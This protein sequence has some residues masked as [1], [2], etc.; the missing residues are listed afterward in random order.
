MPPKPV[1]YISLF[2]K[3]LTKLKPTTLGR[4]DHEY[5]FRGHADSVENILPKIYRKKPVVGKSTVRDKALI[6]NEDKIFKEIIMRA[7][8]E[9]VNEH[10][11]IEKLVKMQHY[12]LSTRL[13][14]VTSNPLVALYFAAQHLTKERE[15]G[16]VVILKIPKNEI[17]FYDSDTVGILANIAKMKSDFSFPEKKSYL[18]HEIRKDVPS[19]SDIIRLADVNSVVPVKVKLNNNRIVRQSGAFLLYG[20]N[21]EKNKPAKINPH[22]IERKI[23]I[24]QKDKAGLLKSLDL[25]GIN[26]SSLYPEIDY[27]AA[28]LIKTYEYNDGNPRI[29]L[30]RIGITTTV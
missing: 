1:D 10:T 9:F 19:F 2:S 20:I 27:Q 13:L 16:E 8:Q 23:T 4:V 7:P 28:H 22:W 30:P 26:G 3:F 6:Q 29:I 18:L 14:D 24:D 11:A 21:G 5:F 15:N 25:L 17:K 12:G